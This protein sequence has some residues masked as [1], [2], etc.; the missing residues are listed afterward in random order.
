MNEISQL[1][2]RIV[3]GKVRRETYYLVPCVECGSERWLRK[4]DARK[5]SGLCFRCSQRVKAHLG[6]QAMCRKYGEK[7]A[8]WHWRA[9]KIE[10]PSSLEEA[11]MLTLGDLG[12]PYEREAVLMTKAKGKRCRAYM[13]DFMVRDADDTQCAIEVNGEYVHSLADAKKRDRAKR[14]LL[15]RRGYPVLVLEEKHI[16]A[17]EA[18][19]LIAAFLRLSEGII[20]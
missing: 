10:H 9:W 18:E 8:I 2:E 15:K 1:R 6:W 11:I 16:R 14:S 3:R 19:R 13:V 17:G 7:W 20:A 12:I 5:C 4:T